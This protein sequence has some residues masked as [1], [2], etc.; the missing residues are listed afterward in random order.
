M[1]DRHFEGMASLLPQIYD[2][3]VDQGT[4]WYL[5]ETVMDARSRVD[6]DSFTR[7]HSLSHFV[8]VLAGFRY[9]KV[10]TQAEEEAWYRKMI[11]ALG[12]S[13]PPQAP[14][15]TAQFFR[16]EGEDLPPG[17][18]LDL[19]VPTVLRTLPGSREAV[20]DHHGSTFR[21]TGV[22][23]CDTRTVVAWS[24]S[25]EPIVASLFPDDFDVLEAE[26]DGI[27]EWAAHELRKKAREAFIRGRVYDF[28]L[29]DDVGTHYQRTRHMGHYTSEEATGAMT[30]KPTVP[31]TASE[32]VVMWHEAIVT[33]A[34]T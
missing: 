2:E 30:Y 17:T 29:L 21:V 22:D 27:D 24:I 33:I 11:S 16:L 26:L 25:P 5:I 19:A 15:G 23:I 28:Q 3:P 7:R 34:T 14:A 6:R 10:I 1:A 13:P 32:L 31:D 4:R 18:E 12:W 20:S 9:Q 8:G